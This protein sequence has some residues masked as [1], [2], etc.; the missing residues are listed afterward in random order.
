MAAHPAFHRGFVDP[1]VVATLNTPSVEASAHRLGAVLRR[2][3]GRGAT[4]LFVARDGLGPDLVA[5]ALA[6]LR[7]AGVEVRFG[8]RLRRL[9]VQGGRAA[10]LD[11][12][13]EGS[14]VLAPTDAVVLAAPPWEAVRLLP[15][16]K[17][18]M[19]HAPIVNLHFARRAPDGSPVRF[20][21]L[22]DALCQW[23]LVRPAG[24]SV[25]VSAGDAAAREDEATLA[26]RAWAEI[27]T[28]AAAFGLPGEWPEAPPPCRVVKE[29]RATPR[30]LPGPPPRPDRLPLPNV[31]LSGDWTVTM[32]PATIEAAV[33]S[34]ELS[35]RAILASA[36]R[37]PH[38]RPVTA[39]A[40]ASPAPATRPGAG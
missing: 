12:G 39:S 9:V 17:V 20:V 25:T 37:R 24:V 4:R 28:A 11:F 38:V 13:E 19:Q 7:A 34:G 5:P 22:V 29:R 23:V 2:M 10:G 18:P 27:R 6:A 33:W 32:L 1:L 35:A 36:G 3:G 31:A 40:T 21:G 26:P 16:T 14:L 8:T 15:H 30:H